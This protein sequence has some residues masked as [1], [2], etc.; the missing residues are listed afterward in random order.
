M[1]EDTFTIVSYKTETGE[2]CLELSSVYLHNCS[3]QKT[4]CVSDEILDVYRGVCR[5]NEKNRSWNRRHKNKKI[6]LGNENFEAQLGMVSASPAEQID[7]DLYLEYLRQLFDEKVFYRAM[8][9]YMKD[10]TECQI[11]ELENVTQAAVSLSIKTFKEKISE[12]YNITE[13]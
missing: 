1:L 4:V 13:E 5:A 10:M 3:E 11:A 12:L 6:Y 7:S 2:N 9:Y 8:L